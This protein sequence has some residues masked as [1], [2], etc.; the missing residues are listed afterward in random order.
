MIEGSAVYCTQYAAYS[1][2]ITGR[3]P[4]IEGTEKEVLQQEL[5]ELRKRKVEL[6]ENEAK[7]AREKHELKELNRLRE[8]ELRCVC[9]CVCV[10]VCSRGTP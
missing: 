9:V 7:I 3:G 5:E 6:A 8:E 2:L 1:L 10:R 4:Q